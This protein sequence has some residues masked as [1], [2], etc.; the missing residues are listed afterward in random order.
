MIRLQ[1]EIVIYITLRRRKVVSNRQDLVWK[2]TTLCIF[3]QYV[4]KVFFGN[5]TVLSIVKRLEAR[6][7]FLFKI[8]VREQVANVLNEFVCDLLIKLW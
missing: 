4:D 1:E 2:E 3:K 7:H 5:V 8:S 6:M